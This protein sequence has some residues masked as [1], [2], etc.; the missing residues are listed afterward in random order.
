[1]NAPDCLRRVRDITNIE[2]TADLQRLVT[3]LARTPSVMDEYHRLIDAFNGDNRLTY[4]IDSLITIHCRRVGMDSHSFH[5]VLD[6]FRVD[7]ILYDECIES[8][9][10]RRIS[11]YVTSKAKRC[12]LHEFEVAAHDTMVVDI[13]RLTISGGMYSVTHHITPRESK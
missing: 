2:P 11:Q 5:K 3:H 6:L 10:H 4:G 9:K 8:V 13:D 12:L 7:N 1:M